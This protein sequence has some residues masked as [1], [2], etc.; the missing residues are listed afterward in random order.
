MRFVWDGN[1]ILHE[2]VSWDNSDIFENL[3]KYS[4][5]NNSEIADN[6]V[7][8]V[9]ND[10]FVPSAKITNEGNYSIIS[11]YLGT[12]VEAY[13][14]QGKP[15]W[16]TELGIYGRMTAFIGKQNFIPFRYQGRYEDV[17][18]GL[19]YNRFRYYSPVDG[20]YTQQDPI[21]LVGD[22]SILCGYVGDPN[23]TVDP[24]GLSSFNSFEFGEITPFPSGLHFGQNRIVPNFSTIGSQAADS[25]VGRPVLEVAKDISL[26]KINPNEFLISYTID[27]ATGKAVTLN[28]R[29]LAAL[30]EGGKF[31]DNVIFVSYDKVPSHLVA[32]IKNR[33]PSTTISITKNKDGSGLVKSVTNCPG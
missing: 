27:L 25:I 21:G 1:T 16:S 11:D 32:D 13:D 18:I 15:V 2:Y 8:W 19:Y 9:I 12:P 10:G 31:P 5:Q 3:V 6:L 33:P 23:I 30:V 17:E 7:T 29:R 20:M 26:G 14:K 28:I 22:N 4:S 24:L